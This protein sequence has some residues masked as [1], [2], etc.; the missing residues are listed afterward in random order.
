[1]H[2]RKPSEGRYKRA[3]NG[4]CKGDCRIMQKFHKTKAHYEM[5]EILLPVKKVN[6]YAVI[7]R[8]SRCNNNSALRVMCGM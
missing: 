7:L 5:T 2:L 1:M 4:L 3:K 8:S 6:C